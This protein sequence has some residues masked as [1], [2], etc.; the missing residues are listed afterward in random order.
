MQKTAYG[1]RISDWS[2]DVCSSDLL[3]ERLLD[4]LGHHQPDAQFLHVTLVAALGEP[5]AN[6]RRGLGT[7]IG[8][9]QRFLAL[10]ERRLVEARQA[11]PGEIADEPIG[12]SLEAAEQLVMPPCV[13][14]P[15]VSQNGKAS[16]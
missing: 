12:R 15:S 3:G 9:D 5:P 8:R 1:M 14:A 10:V 4:L 13:L 6:A 11:E 2:S 7:E 16:C